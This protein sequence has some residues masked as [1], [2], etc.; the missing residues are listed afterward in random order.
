MRI[1]IALL[2]FDVVGSSSVESRCNSSDFEQIDTVASYCC[3][4]EFDHT[5]HAHSCLCPDGYRKTHNRADTIAR[6][7]QK[8]DIYDLFRDTGKLA[9]T[10]TWHSM[11]YVLPFMIYPIVVFFGKLGLHFGSEMESGGERTA[12]KPGGYYH[13]QFEQARVLTW[14][15]KA[16]ILIFVSFSVLEEVSVQ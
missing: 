11:R 9:V 13:N 5:E 15:F 12:A 4:A 2:L 7:T 3:R 14:T 6:C 1:W 16:T 8:M 10:A